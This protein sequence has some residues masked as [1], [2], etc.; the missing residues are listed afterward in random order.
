MAKQAAS[1]EQRVP[2][3]D[4][5]FEQRVPSFVRLSSWSP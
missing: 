3:S 1:Y 4:P 2:L 5:I